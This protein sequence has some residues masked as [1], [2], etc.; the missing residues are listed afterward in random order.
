MNSKHLK[1]LGQKWRREIPF[2]HNI[3]FDVLSH[4]CFMRKLVIYPTVYLNMLAILCQ[5][6][7]TVRFF[8]FFNKSYEKPSPRKYVYKLLHCFPNYIVV[9]IVISA[10]IQYVHQQYFFIVFLTKHR[11][12]SPVCVRV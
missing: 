7:S 8:F 12:L 2:P 6:G 9:I 11:I 1:S 4:I 10:Y 5:H 3:Q